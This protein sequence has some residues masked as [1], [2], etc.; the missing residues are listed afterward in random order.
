MYIQNVAFQALNKIKTCLSTKDLECLG[1]D[2][3]V[4]K[5]SEKKEN[6]NIIKMY[7]QAGRNVNFYSG[8]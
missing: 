4:E 8:L 7:L 2:Q 3:P 6:S 1:N 5:N